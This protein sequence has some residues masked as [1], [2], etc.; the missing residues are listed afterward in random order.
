MSDVRLPTITSRPRKSS[1]SEGVVKIDVPFL[2]FTTAST[3]KEDPTAPRHST[4]TQ[5]K[6][7]RHARKPHWNSS[8]NF[9]TATKSS[10]LNKERARFTS[11]ITT[12][13]EHTNCQGRKERGSQSI[14][15]ENRKGDIQLMSA[16]SRRTVVVKACH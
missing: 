12:C 3:R 13:L 5:K 10:R 8:D 1:F 14:P 2:P 9:F 6:Y 4:Y 15:K 16:I 11:G 7:Q